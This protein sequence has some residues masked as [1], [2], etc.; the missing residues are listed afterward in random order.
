[1]V[2]GVQVMIGVMAQTRRFAADLERAARQY[3][4]QG[5]RELEKFRQQQH[6]AI[7]QTG[8]GFNMWLK[9]VVKLYIQVLDTASRRAATFTLYFCAGL[10]QYYQ[11]RSLSCSIAGTRKMHLRIVDSIK[12]L[13]FQINLFTKAL[14]NYV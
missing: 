12:I 9:R 4:E 6:L 10:D 7:N 11:C 14:I 1:M 5:S 3:R 8:R 13:D 2:T